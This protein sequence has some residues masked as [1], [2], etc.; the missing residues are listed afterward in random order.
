MGVLNKYL[1]SLIQEFFFRHMAIILE[2]VSVH[3]LGGS[4]P[5]YFPKLHFNVLFLTLSDAKDIKHLCT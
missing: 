2:R 3:E 5:R 1:L 4:Y